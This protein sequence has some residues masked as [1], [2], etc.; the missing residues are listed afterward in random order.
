MGQRR[1]EL[2]G[3]IGAF[4]AH[5]D[6]PKPQTGPLMGLPITIK[7]QFH[8]AGTR[9]GFGFGQLAKSPSKQDAA[10]LAALRKNGADFIGRTNMPPLALDFQAV[11]GAGHRT[12]NPA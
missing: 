8:L 11:D 2:D 10:A 5:E 3:D 6:L 1:R 7:D 12:N 9:L 4:C